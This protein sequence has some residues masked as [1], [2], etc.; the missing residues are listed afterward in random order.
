MKTEELSK[1]LIFG[2]NADKAEIIS[3]LQHLGVMHIAKARPDA[4][5]GQDSPAS[6]VDIM[7]HLL[8]KLQY[9]ATQTNIATQF[10]LEGLPPKA[11][12]IEQAEE[13]IEKHLTKI[14]ELSKE[15][16]R[17]LKEKSKV[18]AQKRIIESLP[19][20][21][22]KQGLKGHLRIILQ[23]TEDLSKYPFPVK[24]KI[25]QSAKAGKKYF[26]ELSVMNKDLGKFNTSLR[27][28][29]SRQLNIPDMP[30]GSAHFLKQIE[31]QSQELEKKI[32]EIDNDLFKKVN[33]KQSKIQFLITS[34]ENYRKQANIS[35]LF[36]R[37]P[38]FF[39]IQGYVR[40]SDV[41]RIKNSFPE[42][43]IYSQPAQSDAPSKLKNKGFAK[44]FE[45]ITTMFGI[46]T[47]SLIDPT[48]L[49]S[50]FFPFFFG[51]MLSDIGYGFLLLFAVIALYFHL[52]EKFEKAAIIF[53]SSAI[54]SMIFGAIFGSFFGNL[55]EITPLY[56]DS[57]SA[58]F[59]ILKI[60]LI[61]GLI[62]INLGV[63]LQVYQQFLKKETFF[64]A[65]SQ[66]APIPLIEA[67]VVLLY[68]KQFIPASIATV[69]LFFFLIKEKGLF[70]IMDIT[71][72]FGTW[73]SYARL[74]ALSLATAGVALAVNIVAEKALSLGKVGIILWAIVIGLGHLFNFVLNILGCAIH[75]ARLHY[76]EFF[77]L[78][79]EGDGYEF[80]EF[81]VQRKT[82]SQKP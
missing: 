30:L 45:M 61:I 21:L 32:K 15:K 14:E 79:F 28:S 20:A 53:G 77:S 37:S 68:F 80:K 33:G 9:I 25:E 72:F 74:L 44:N 71:G 47:Y 82:N 24:V 67:T 11:K 62:H 69:I 2:S 70:G 27:K 19:F 5:L 26:T 6:D 73:F 1:L 12:V 63:L 49:V 34:L 36:L 38:N 41:E 8:L 3:R 43:T 22:K 48:P 56:Q 58:S 60:S 17:V 13:F 40:T 31:R 57:F 64:K 78:F 54:S 65:L 23:S 81:A 46:P 55:I 18:A 4:A 42:T 29:R 66:I 51:F 50:I 10:T 59:T 39:A 76:V 52:G 35:A 7:S 75:S 16:K